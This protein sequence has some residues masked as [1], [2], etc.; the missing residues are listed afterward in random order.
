MAAALYGADGFYRSAGAPG[1][2][3]RTAAH[4]G[5]IWATAIATQV[6][7][8][9]DD[10]GQ[11]ADFTVV[12][13]GAGNGELL[14][15]L[16]QIGSDRW[17]L[18][19]VDV[20]PR[21]DRLPSTID[22]RSE[23]PEEFV[24]VLL[25][26]EW[27]DVVP[28]DVVELTDDGPRLVEVRADGEERLG[29][30]VSDRDSAWLDQWWPLA[31]VGDRAE[32]GWPRDEAWDDAVARLKT[33]VAIAIDYAAVPARDVAGTLTGYKEGRQVMPVP[34]GSMDITAHVLF[35]SLGPGEL[36]TQREALRHLGVR[37]ER[38]QRDGDTAHYLAALAHAGDEAEL[39]DPGGLGGF[40]WLVQT[41]GG[42]PT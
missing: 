24:G 38:P 8:I 11:P 22:W 27:L 9:H 30:A 12:E 31:D 10:L 15:A 41:V 19:G 20:A 40:T 16:A 42:S 1:R 7:Q 14:E 35:E 37:G 3:F 4:T 39:I 34:D 17:R 23:L 36:L 33:G 26:V 32:V 21:P 6:E 28:V 13:V 5:H 25:A 2:H 18:F 29:A